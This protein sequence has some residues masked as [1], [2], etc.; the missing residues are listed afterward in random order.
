VLGLVC[1]LVVTRTKHL[2]L[3]AKGKRPGPVICETWMTI[4]T[5]WVILLLPPGLE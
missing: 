5:V 2:V 3:V 1:A 4:V